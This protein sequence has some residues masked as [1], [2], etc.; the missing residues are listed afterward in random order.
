MLK[1]T[2]R[3]WILL[4][5]DHNIFSAPGPNRPGADFFKKNKKILKTCFFCQGLVQV[6]VLFYGHSK[7]KT[8]NKTKF[9]HK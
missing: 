2:N 1:S 7:G 6:G 4:N 8:Q 9:N 5:F 3:F